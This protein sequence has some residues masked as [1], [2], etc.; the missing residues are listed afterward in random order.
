MN[1]GQTTLPHDV[2]MSPISPR[3]EALRRFAETSLSARN[4]VI[5][6]ASED[7]SFRSYWRIRDG[8]R[9]TV[10][11]DAPPDKENVEPWLDVGPRLRDA[12]LHAPEVFAMDRAQGFV[13]MEDLGTRMYLPALNETTVDTLYSQA[14]DALLRMQTHVAVAGLPHFNEAFM[15]IELELMPEW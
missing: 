4:L 13:L 2:D 8:R 7:A 10:A 11:M 3:A 9:T 1:P 5:E 14:L 6:P 15:T 12:G